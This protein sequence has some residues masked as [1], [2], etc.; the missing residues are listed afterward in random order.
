MNTLKS[1]GCAYILIFFAAVF[2]VPAFA[3]FCQDEGGT[4][5]YCA[6]VC[7]TLSGVNILLYYT[8]M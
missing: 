2:S 8:C 5:D 7:G 6:K 4:P 3:F 1:R